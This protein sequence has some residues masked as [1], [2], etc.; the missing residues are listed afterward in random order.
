MYSLTSKNY[1]GT[2]NLTEYEPFFATYRVGI[3]TFTQE[4]KLR[5]Y[6]RENYNFC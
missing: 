2:N 6:G 3:K 4:Y 1:I 5:H